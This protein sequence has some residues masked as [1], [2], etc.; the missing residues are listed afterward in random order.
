MASG[1]AALARY[2][3]EQ[4]DEKLESARLL[5]AHGQHRDSVSRSYYAMLAAARALL[6]LRDVNPRTHARV[7]GAIG[8]SFVKTGELPLRTSRL[9]KEAMDLREDS[10]YGD[11]VEVTDEDSAKQL[12]DAEAFVEEARRVGRKLGLAERSGGGGRRK[13]SGGR[14]GRAR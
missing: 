2:R 7:V 14:G 9:L 12:R 5:H 13:G 8:E 6:A 11:F 4:A 10:D 1:R 3:M